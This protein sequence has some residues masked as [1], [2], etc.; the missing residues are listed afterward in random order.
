MGMLHQSTPIWC[1]QDMVNALK[2]VL[3]HPDGVAL[4][5]SSRMK[6]IYAALMQMAELSGPSARAPASASRA[7]E[8]TK[9]RSVVDL[10]IAHSDLPPNASYDDLMAQAHASYKIIE[11]TGGSDCDEAF[12]C[13]L[14]PNQLSTASPGAF[15]PG[16]SAVSSRADS[17][18]RLSFTPTANLD[19][20]PAHC[21]PAARFSSID[22]Y[23]SSTP[24]ALSRH[25]GFGGAAHVGSTPS[26][27][28]M[29]REGSSPMLSTPHTS[30]LADTPS[31]AG[32]PLGAYSYMASSP[33]ARE[34][35]P[36]LP[37]TAGAAA[38]GAPQL[39]LRVRTRV[40]DGAMPGAACA[41]PQPPSARA[42]AVPP[43]PCSAR[44]E[45]PM[46]RAGVFMAR[47]GGANAGAGGSAHNAAVPGVAAGGSSA[48]AMPAADGAGSSAGSGAPTPAS[49][50]AN[51]RGKL[52][53]KLLPGRVR[54][55]GRGRGNA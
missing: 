9:A 22:P 34:R 41:V 35:L 11:T 54:G 44:R 50:I 47:D 49:Q 26:P 39:G 29:M 16:S 37:P 33:L 36:P 42:V 31:A 5:T 12:E 6:P 25:C 21:S 10:L 13:L 3:K 46:A 23:D 53:D 43:Q 20:S 15:E 24:S 17:V 7:S 27:S 38:T 51:W 2:Q 4:A 40:A 1:M 8:L 28:A 30:P 32:T 52:Q 19:C 18:R 45:H 48:A 55:R 14:S